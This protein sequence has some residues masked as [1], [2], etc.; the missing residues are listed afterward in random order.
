MLLLRCA[1]GYVCVGMCVGVQVCA[2]CV[3]LVCVC[4]C[5]RVCI[6]QHKQIGNPSPFA[7]VKDAFAQSR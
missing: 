2:H 4:V 7:S 1:R 5:V 6:S 3:C